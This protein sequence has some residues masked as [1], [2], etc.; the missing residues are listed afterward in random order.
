MMGE[1]LVQ[2]PKED[3][4]A[5]NSDMISEEQAQ[6]INAVLNVVK[7]VTTNDFTAYKK[8]TIIRRITR[9]MAEKK[10]EDLQDYLSLL[11]EHPEEARILANEFLIGVTRFFRDAAA[12]QFVEEEIVPNIL[13]NKPDNT[14][15]KAW[16]PPVALERKPIQWLYCFRSIW[17][18]RVS[19]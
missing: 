13:A 18:S 15:V 10:I 4:A 14:Q 12:F 19:I 8:Q 5:E 9:R 7:K 17:I 1:K 16:V 3:L 2:H 6:A 11:Q